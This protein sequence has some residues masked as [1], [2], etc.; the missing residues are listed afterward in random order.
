MR[1]A[2][3]RWNCVD[4]DGV[5]EYCR[6][7]LVG[8]VVGPRARATFPVTQLERSNAIL[9]TPRE[10]LQVERRGATFLLWC[11]GTVLG[12]AAASEFKEREQ[13]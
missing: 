8:T 7:T 10:L 2:T 9:R 11:Q 6:R 1:V 5:R 3:G 4:K 13:C 12:R